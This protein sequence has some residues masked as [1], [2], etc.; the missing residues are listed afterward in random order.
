MKK[1]HVIILIVSVAVLAVVLYIQLSGDKKTDAGIHR[2][3]A[4]EVLQTGSYTYVKVSEGRKDYWVAIN[5]ADIKVGGTYF[6]LKGMEMTQFKS[7]ELNR[8]FASILFI[9]TFSETP[10]VLT[11]PPAGESMGRGMMPGMS[12][13]GRQKAAEK[14]GISVAKAEG[15]ITIAELYS[16][17]KSFEGKTVQ[18]RGE[19]VKFSPHIMD[20]NWVHVQDGTRDGGDYD[21][22]VTTRDTVLVGE[23]KIFEG[24]IARDVDF[25]SGYTYEVIMQEARIK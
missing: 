25:G 2:V 8:E 12:M 10:D 4:E 23:T 7:K 9:E 18:I 14:Q 19:V 6:W 22:V 15:G 5:W 21:L 16:D 24:V 1:N 20:R 17:R 3:K 13:A 11:G